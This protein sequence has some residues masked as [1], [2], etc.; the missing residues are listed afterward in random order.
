MVEQ[1]GKQQLFN[2]KLTTLT[3][4][5]VCSGKSSFV[6]SILQMLEVHSGTIVVDDTDLSSISR[7]SIRTRVITVP[8][9]FALLDEPIRFALDP[10]EEHSDDTIIEALRK[11]RIWDILQEKQGLETMGSQISI[12][13]GQ[14]QLFALARA[15][16][17]SGSIVILDE[18]CSR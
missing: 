10:N 1:E 3:L 11:V 15:T 14:R 7:E 13:H 12:S 9:D 8:Q 18:A 16:L 4:L 2:I 17:S 6:L 5:T